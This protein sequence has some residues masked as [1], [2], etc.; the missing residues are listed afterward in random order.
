MNDHSSQTDSV[1]ALSTAIAAVVG[2]RQDLRAGAAEAT[3]LE[4]NRTELARLQRALSAALIRRHLPAA[5]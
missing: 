5:A 2:R 1:E 3:A 4:R